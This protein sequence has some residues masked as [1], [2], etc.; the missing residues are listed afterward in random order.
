M[1]FSE[2][3]FEEFK[4]EALEL[5][6][7]AE[8]SLLQLDKGADFR[9]TFDAVFRGFHNLKGAAGMME[10]VELQRHTHE[11][12]SILMSFKDSNGIPQEYVSMFLL[13]IDGARALL[14]RKVISFDYTVSRSS[15]APVLPETSPKV[16][17]Q[18]QKEIEKTSPA[19]EKPLQAV[20][21]PVPNDEFL[22]E[23]EEILER[24]SKSL[25]LVEHGTH[26][27][28]TVDSL[29]RDIHSLKGASY[30][31]SYQNIGDLS[32]AMESSLETVRDAT[33]LASPHLI[34]LLYKSIETIETEINFIKMQKPNPG[35]EMLSSYYPKNSPRQQQNFK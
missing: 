24:I 5:L 15:S 1:S 20:S 9:T 16:E 27:K 21:N 2:Q 17:T 19:M 22:A 4:V 32:H 10:L 23:T 13:G 12:E 18:V 34:R 11:L 25:E 8:S 3:E 35:G 30:L 33:H 6:E 7:L 29:Y 14:D 31:F 26:T 28:E